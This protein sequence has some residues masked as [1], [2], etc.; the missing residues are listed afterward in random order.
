MHIQHLLHTEI[1]FAQYDQCIEQS[2]NGLIYATSTYLNCIAPYWELLMLGDYEAVMPLPCRSKFGIKYVFQPIFTAQLGIFS[3][4][5]IHEALTNAFIT[6]L[7]QV[8][9]FAALDLNSACK[10]NDF[11][12]RN[13]Y[14]LD[15]NKPYSAVQES[16]NRLAKRKINKAIEATLTINNTIPAQDILDLSI[17]NIVDQNIN[18]SKQDFNDAKQLILALAKKQ[19]L[20]TIAAIDG[21][22]KI[23]AGIIYFRYKNRIYNVIAG[24]SKESYELGAFYF[25]L[26]GIIQKYCEQPYLLD[27]EGS[28]I[29]GIAFVFKN[30]GGS[31]EHFYYYKYNN[32]PFP[33]SQLK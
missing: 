11:T 18:Y 22:G 15:L 29:E 26:D 19:Q 2:G 30:L 3:S 1:D 6:Q 20:Y 9:K 12:L 16:Y 23:H 13:N 25:C 8:V 33:L 5:P 4:Y 27:F 31:L 24:V 14:T 32:L 10:H 17:T 21:T 28:D 7:K